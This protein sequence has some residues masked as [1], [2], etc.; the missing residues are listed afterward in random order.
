MGSS[1]LAAARGPDQLLL[2][3]DTP[4]TAAS[5]Q[6]DGTAGISTATRL[7]AQEAQVDSTM[8]T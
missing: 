8:E 1:R 3:I 2:D 5:C 4:V 6:L 7:T